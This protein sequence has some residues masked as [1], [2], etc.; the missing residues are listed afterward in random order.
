MRKLFVFLIL[1]GVFLAPALADRSI[2]K[3]VAA[4]ADGEVSIELI[5]GSVRIVGWDRNEVQVTGTVGDDVEEVEI[6]AE[7]G[8]VSIEVELPDSDDHS[9]DTRTFNDASADLEIHVPRGCTVEAESISAGFE[10]EGLTGAVDVESISGEIELQGSV[11][12]IDLASI[13][14]RISV[15]SDEPLEEGSFETI[16]G[17][18]EV[19]AALAAGGDF[20]FETVSGNV[21][22][23]L[24][25]N[26]SADFDVETFSG[27][28]ENEFGPRA[29]RTSEY[30]PGKELE[31]TI[32]GGDADVEVESF[33]GKIEILID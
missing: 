9:S 3:T 30:A 17:S 29:E 16:S 10:L 6:E 4:D 14:G 18:I 23:R 11:S 1:S 32:G 8:N 2:D 33:S 20:S 12:E 22:L 7:G 27:R 21:E 25:A 24:P 5:A 15:E 28:I 31:F 26:T 19:R 13:S